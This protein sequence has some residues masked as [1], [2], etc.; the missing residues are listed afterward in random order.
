MSLLA[1]HLIQYS[2][3]LSMAIIIF[4]NLYSDI[5]VFGVHD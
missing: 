2:L 4:K 1:I 5:K 3:T